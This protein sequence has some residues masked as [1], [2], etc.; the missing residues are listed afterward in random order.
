VGETRS[1]DGLAPE[2][3]SE[4][5]D[6]V[7]SGGPG[8]GLSDSPFWRRESTRRA[9]DAEGTGT[10]EQ[11]DGV[12]RDSEGWCGG[13]ACRCTDLGLVESDDLFFVSEVDLDVPPADIGSEDLLGIKVRVG[14]DQEGRVPVE[15]F[16]ASRESVF[17][18]SDGEEAQTPLR[19][20]GSPEEGGLGFVS[21][22]VDFAGR[23]DLGGLPLDG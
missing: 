8:F 22:G 17:Q 23:V 18:G 19:S 11:Q 4:V 12:G 3:E 16:G 9:V 21:H 10:G 6:K 2:L 5:V 20:D 15:D 1:A 14:T 13:G 7:G